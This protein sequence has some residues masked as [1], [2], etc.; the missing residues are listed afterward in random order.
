MTSAS[1][2]LLTCPTHLLTYSPTHLLTYSR[3]VSYS[4]DGGET[5]VS[6]GSKCSGTIY[7]CEISGLPA[8]T[9]TPTLTL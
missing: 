9:L 2:F 5:W 8:G 7:E 1:C 4:T 6:A 3:K